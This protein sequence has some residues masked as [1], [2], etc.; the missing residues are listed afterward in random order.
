[1]KLWLAEQADA[2]EEKMKEKKAQ[3]GAGGRNMLMAIPPHGP[4]IHR[5]GR[6]LIG[7]GPEFEGPEQRLEMEVYLPGRAYEGGKAEGKTDLDH[8]I[9]LVGTALV[10]SPVTNVRLR[11]LC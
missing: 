8:L 9:K 10:A 2:L 11:I 5:G 7:A 6:P 1:M 4:P 3:K